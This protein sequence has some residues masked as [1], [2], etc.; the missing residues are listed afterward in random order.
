MSLSP[1]INTV[2]EKGVHV[3]WSYACFTD[4]VLWQLIKKR[5]TFMQSVSLKG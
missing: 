4:I 2:G 3:M 1:F 5:F